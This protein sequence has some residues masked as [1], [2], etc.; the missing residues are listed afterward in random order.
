MHIHRQQALDY[1][2][3][4]D[5]TDHG[6]P[7]WRPHLNK[8]HKLTLLSLINQMSKNCIPL[9][10]EGVCEIAKALAEVCMYTI[11]VV[12]DNIVYMYVE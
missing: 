11:H 9:Q 7:D 5:V 8:F 4:I 12:H 10:E 3:T 2:K 6:N 1:V